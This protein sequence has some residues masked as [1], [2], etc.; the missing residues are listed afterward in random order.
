MMWDNEIQA[1][2]LFEEI[3]NTGFLEGRIYTNTIAKEVGV[4]QST[5]SRELNYN[6]TFVRTVLGSWQYKQIMRKVTP[7]QDINKRTRRLN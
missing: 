1:F 7:N 5:I 3:S 4:H 2:R 6:I